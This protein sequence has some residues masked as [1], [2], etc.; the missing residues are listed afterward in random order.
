M[1]N[2]PLSL[3]PRKGDFRSDERKSIALMS[4]SPSSGVFRQGRPIGFEL[5]LARHPWMV[6]RFLFRH[7]PALLAEMVGFRPIKFCSHMSFWPV[8]CF[9]STAN[10]FKIEF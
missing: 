6:G 4:F 8:C 10:Q 2:A 3:L 5:A 1:G 9:S 7:L